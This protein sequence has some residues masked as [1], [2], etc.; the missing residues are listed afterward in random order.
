MTQS[1]FPC[2]TIS[3]QHQHVR[4]QRY[5]NPLINWN[6]K[7]EKEAECVDREIQLP[8]GKVIGGSSSINSMVYM[9]GHPLDYD[10]WSEKY[11]L[12]EWTFDKCLPYFKKCE[13]SDRGESEW[14][15]GIQHGDLLAI[16]SDAAAVVG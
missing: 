10:R 3:K 13:S 6:Y 1:L 12:N 4:M 7:S 11:D 16:K 15:G 8:R 5:K 9:R 14:R 2:R